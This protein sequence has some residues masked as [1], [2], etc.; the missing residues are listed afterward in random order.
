MKIVRSRLAGRRRLGYPAPVAATGIANVTFTVR[1]QPLSLQARLLLAALV[2]LLFFVLLT[3]LALDRAYRQS[4]ETAMRERLQDRL[5][6]ILAVLDVD[7]RDRPRFERELPD[8]RLQQPASGFY[9]QI[10]NTRGQVLLRSPS[11]LGIAL[12]P[13]D[14]L[15]TGERHF[16]RID[17]EGRPHQQLHYALDWETEDGR[18]VPLQVRLLLDRQPLSEQIGAFRRT[19][20]Q[21]LGGAALLLL[22]SLVLVLRWSLWPLRRVT[23]ALARMERGEQTDLGGPYPRELQQLTER[24]D[25]LLAHNR[26][27][28][29][30]YRDALG[31]LAH[32]LK[33]PLAILANAIER[34][35]DTDIDT[36]RGAV[37]RIREIIDHQLQRAV[38]AGPIDQPPVTLR[39]QL[40]RLLQTLRRVHDDQP[41]RVDVAIPDDLKLRMDTGDLLEVFGNLLDNAFK[42][43]RSRIRISGE[44][45]GRRIEI[46]IE[47]DGPGIADEHKDAVRRRGQRADEQVEGHGIGLSMVQEILLLYGGELRIDDSALG[48]AR[49]T[50]VL[51]A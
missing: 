4:A 15:P 8:P 19:L 28:L 41:T 30:R 35:A 20:W 37:Q 6:A 43:T 49:M 50:V 27:Q 23:T 32:S 47:D 10:E 44:R 7:T 2:V 38:A 1:R 36:A 17:I 26:R 34:P 14:P 18:R 13:A 33:T 42:W 11:L 12:P 31:N 16:D 5:Y 3:G 45:R 39:P 21:W 51:P 48:G 24:L 46:H 29:Q 40:E 22:L 9:V 25:D